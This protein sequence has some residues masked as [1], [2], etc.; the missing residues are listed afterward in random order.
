MPR[1][2]HFILARFLWWGKDLFCQCHRESP[3]TCVGITRWSRDPEAFLRNYRVLI[4]GILAHS[5]NTKILLQSVYPVGENTSFSLPINELNQQI[6]NLNMHIS[7]LAKE[8]EAVD[9]INT[10]ALLMSESGALSSIYDSGDGIHLT[11]EAYHIILPFLCQR[12]M[13]IE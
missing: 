6:N 7:T 1:Y 5:P 9:Y 8:Y 2:A 13:E 4:D 3:T 12:I 11:N 10:A